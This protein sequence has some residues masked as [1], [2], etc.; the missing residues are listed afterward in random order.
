MQID[1]LVANLTDQKRALSIR[2]PLNWA[3]RM[4]ACWMFKEDII[5]AELGLKSNLTRDES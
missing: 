4:S 1:Q 5:T 3:E 2:I